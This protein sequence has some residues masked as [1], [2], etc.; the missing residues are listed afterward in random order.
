MGL[1]LLVAVHFIFSVANNL[2]HSIFPWDAFTTW[3]Y[4]AKAWVLEDTITPLIYSDEW[5]AKGGGESFAVYA[6]EYPTTLSILAA[7]PTSLAD[8]WNARAASL[9]WSFALLA[10]A[11]TSFGAARLAGHSRMISLL[12]VYFLSSSA[13]LTAHASFAGYGDIWMALSS[14]MGLALLLVWRVAGSPSALWLGLSLLAVGAQFKTEGWLWLGLGF[15]FIVLD[16]TLVAVRWQWLLLC[17]IAI[18]LLFISL[19]LTTV[20]LGPLGQWGITDTRVYVGLIGDYALRPYNPATDYWRSFT[21]SPNFHLLAVSVTGALAVITINHKEKARPF[22]ILLGLIAISQ[23]IIF[24]LSDKSLFA[25]SGTAINRLVL[26]F[27]P[28]FVFT[29]GHA[30][31]QLETAHR[32][33]STKQFFTGIALTITVFIIS[34]QVMFSAQTADTVSPISLDSDDFIAVLGNTKKVLVNQNSAI[35]FSSSDGGVGVLKAPMGIE[36][37]QLPSLV[38]ISATVA[39]PGTTFFYWMNRQ[40]APDLHRIPMN[41]GTSHL[42]DLKT[43][44]AW[45]IDSIAEYGVAVAADGFNTTLIRRMDFMPNLGWQDIPALAINWIAPITPTQITLNDLRQPVVSEM[46][47]SILLNFSA[48]ILLSLLLVTI[49]TQQRKLSALAQQPI[50]IGLFALWVASD[51]AWLIQTKAWPRLSATENKTWAALSGAHLDEPSRLAKAHLETDKPVLIIPATADANFEAQKLPYMLLPR[52]SAFVGPGDTSLAQDWPGN[53]VVLGKYAG[54]VDK[55][56]LQL[57]MI[58]TGD[59]INAHPTL[60]IVR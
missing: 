20:S 15:A 38:K 37:E 8:G 32:A 9:P 36:V 26:H 6:S 28:V 56:A 29:A 14:G 11:F 54:D 48:A 59:I 35:T 53:I 50:L 24:G 21:H 1:L 60:A 30:L 33:I 45:G 2:N 27:L 16:K 25:Q 52:K 5:L 31:A 23:I 44:S 55:V 18:A 47:L 51:I 41:I 17:V 34:I 19:D 46:G 13:L 39:S 22:W 12:G 10:L 42:L 49:T 40:S 3:M 58:R 43:R 7:F 57:Q 4:R